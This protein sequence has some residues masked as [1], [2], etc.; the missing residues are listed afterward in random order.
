MANFDLFLPMLLRFE[1]GFVDDPVDP[2]GATNKGITLKTFTGSARN[3][4]GVEPTLDRLKNLT[5]DQAGVIYKAL[6]WNKIRGDEIGSQ[7]LANIVCDFYVN[8]GSHATK[9]LQSILNQM[10]GNLTI[11]GEIGPTSIQA[12]ASVDQGEVYRQ[13]KQGRIAYYRNLVQEQPSLV[14]F[15]NGWL[16]RVNSFPDV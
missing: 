8:A 15:L 14:R 10:G 9:L 2:G 7:N 12:L 11:D 5:D 1:G 3:L 6:Y 13:Y 4:L 16:N